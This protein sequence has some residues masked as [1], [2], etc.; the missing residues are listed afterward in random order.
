MMTTTD[1]E[2]SSGSLLHQ[3]VGIENAI[4]TYSAARSPYG[5]MGGMDNVMTL[6][7]K[8]RNSFGRRI[9][10]LEL[11]QNLQLLPCRAHI[12]TSRGP[13]LASIDDAGGAFGGDIRTQ[14]IGSTICALAH[15]CEPS[16]AAQLFCRFFLPYFFGK[17]NPLADS[18]HSQLVEKSC[19]TQII[20]EGASRG[21]NDLFIRT[22]NE[23]ELPVANQGWKSHKLAMQAY[24]GQI[25]EVNMIGGLLRFLTQDES[26]HYST[27]SSAVACVAIC[28]KAVGHNVGSIHTWDGQGKPPNAMNPRSL[29]LVLGG[30]SIT[31]PLMEEEI[32]IPNTTLILHYQYQTVGSMLMSA[33]QCKLDILVET[34]QQDFEH[35]FEYVETNVQ[36][37][38]VMRKNMTTAAAEFSWRHSSRKVSSIAKRLA[39]IHFPICAELVAPCYERI[40]SEHYFTMIRPKVRGRI[41]SGRPELARFRAIT[42]AIAISIAGRLAPFNFKNVFHST[43]MELDDGFRLTEV[44]TVLDNHMDT[45]SRLP[46]GTA[47]AILAAVHAAH[48][49]GFER[50]KDRIIGWRNGIYGIVPDLLLKMTIDSPRIHLVCIDYFWANVKVREDGSIHSSRTTGIQPYEPDSVIEALALQKLNEPGLGQANLC[51]PDIPLHLSFGTPMIPREPELCIVGRIGGSIVG[52]VGIEDILESILR[53]NVEPKTCPGHTTRTEVWNVSTSAWARENY[54]KP[55]S[56]QYSTFVSVKGDHCWALFLAGQTGVGHNGRVIFQCVDCAIENFTEAHELTSGKER[57][58]VFAGLFPQAS[59]SLPAG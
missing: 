27:K 35:V 30:S 25:G 9:Q 59:E 58:G 50:H 5:W 40:A 3:E 55:M 18:L 57:P 51:S 48:E 22:L 10:Q 14:I 16:T 7:T 19:L 43:V 17:S 20:N 46:M 1:L 41:K 32:Q 33:M 8:I 53:S 6:L 37:D 39:T 24:D 31:D 28:L 56:W 54:I 13:I 45:G 36:A 21:Y 47:I 11:D 15:L 26:S 44:C 38:F 4:A 12:L 29:T 2:A 23:L 49:D 52:T 34:L 42:A